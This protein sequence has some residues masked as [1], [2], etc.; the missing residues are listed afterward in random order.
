LKGR[1]Q[2]VLEVASEGEFK[3]MVDILKR[4]KIFEAGQ[5]YG[6]QGL[7]DIIADQSLLPEAIDPTNVEEL[8]RVMECINIALPFFKK[9]IVDN[10]MSLNIVEKIMPVFEKFKAAN[11]ATILQRLC[12]LG[13]FV[14]TEA[15]TKCIPRI[16]ELLMGQLATPPAKTEEKPEEE[17]KEIELPE[18]AFTFVEALLFL[19]HQYGAK[20]G[21]QLKMVSGIPLVESEGGNEETYAL[22]KEKLLCTYEVSDAVLR[23]LKD[24]VPKAKSTKTPEDQ[25]RK[26]NLDRGI[27]AIRNVTDLSRPLATGKPY[28]LQTL[29]SGKFSWQAATTAAGMKRA[30][31]ATSEGK[32][33]KKPTPLTYVPP[34]RR[35]G[36]PKAAS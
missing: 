7:V 16:F 9:G 30:A 17:K 34:S 19:V 35:P 20:D 5:K 32:P 18:I 31:P 1:I 21:A 4:L 2:Q 14:P 8:L 33:A 28:C 22:F 29:P 24:V 3:S 25:E 10:K 12:Q 15:A 6:P 11:Q 23:K 26:R 36:Q 13:C 27:V